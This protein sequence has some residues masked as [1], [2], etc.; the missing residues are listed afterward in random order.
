MEQEPRAITMLRAEEFI[1]SV[2]QDRINE[3]GEEIGKHLRAIMEETPLSQ[4]REFS[5]IQLARRRAAGPA[6]QAM[7]DFCNNAVLE[8]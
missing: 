4:F 3:G 6:L 7:V 2:V 8:A 1:Q 5:A